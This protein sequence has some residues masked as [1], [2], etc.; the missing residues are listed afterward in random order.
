MGSNTQSTIDNKC[1]APQASSKE[2]DRDARFL[3]MLPRIRRQAAYYL[4]HLST[5]ERAEAVHEVVAN[6]FVSWVRLND[7]GKP[8][9]AY[10]GPLA[11]Y[12]TCQYLS[13]RRV[14]N[15]MNGHDI[16]SD[17]CQRRKKLVVEQLD[18]FDAPADEWQEI[19]VEDKHS[20]PAD[21]AS[22]RIDFRVWLAQ[23]TRRKRQ[24]AKDL[25]QG[26]STSEVACKHGLSASR[27]S[28]LR[29]ELYDAWCVFTG[30]AA[31]ATSSALV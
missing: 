8:D 24:I 21:V 11:R 6:A 26:Y 14:G 22:T 19:V 1:S 10:A 3:E 20:G 27:V 28:Q 15:R 23:L 17:Y 2:L 7:R 12:G 4:R 9:V 16:T 31:P 18:H 13:G 25:A 29:R 30:E 5:E